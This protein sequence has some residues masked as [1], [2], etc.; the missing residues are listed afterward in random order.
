MADYEPGKM[1]ISAHK[2]CFEIFWN[3]TVRTTII[4]IVLLGVIYVAFA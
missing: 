4:C 1:D 2:E 3:W